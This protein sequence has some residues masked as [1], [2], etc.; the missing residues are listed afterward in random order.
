MARRS[1]ALRHK[2]SVLRKTK[3]ENA[4][5]G[6]TN[7]WNVVDTPRADFY[8]KK[9]RSTELNQQEID[10]YTVCFDVRRKS[11]VQIKETDRIE[12]EDSLY[13]VSFIQPSVDKRW[14]TITCQRI[15]E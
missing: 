14:R 7:E 13:Q 5:G 1:G 8:Y 15:N 11:K 4:Y 10:L 6:I 2:I 3:T 12:Y 9:A